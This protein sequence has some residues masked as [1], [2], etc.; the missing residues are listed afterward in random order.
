MEAKLE[1]HSRTKNKLEDEL[2]FAINQKNEIA[3]TEKLLVQV[4]QVQ[5][6]KSVFEAKLQSIG[7][8]DA[9]QARFQQLQE[10]N[11]KQKD[12]IELMEKEVSILETQQIKVSAEF[13]DAKPQIEKAKQLDTILI[14]KENQLAHAKIDEKNALLQK[15]Q[16]E[17]DRR[18]QPKNC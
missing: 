11:T 4:E 10:K 9:L 17:K 18:E 15:Q 1:R 16:T 14:Q 2:Q 7:Q 8:Q 3:D 12:E 5:A 6:I 13:A